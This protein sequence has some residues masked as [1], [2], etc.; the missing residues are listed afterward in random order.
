MTKDHIGGHRIKRVDPD[1]IAEEIGLES[2]DILLS[3]NNNKII[4]ILDYKEH[5][6]GEEL[7]LLVEKK[8]KSQW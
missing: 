2:G 8:D 5:L 4:D 7:T 1:S 6:A 3:I